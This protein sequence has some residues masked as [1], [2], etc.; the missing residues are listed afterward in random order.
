MLLVHKRSLTPIDP[1]PALKH[2]GANNLDNSAIEGNY[3]LL[4]NVDIVQREGVWH[5]LFEFDSRAT[6]QKGAL[7]QFVGKGQD[8]PDDMNWKTWLGPDVTVITAAVR[9][10]ILRMPADEAHTGAVITDMRQV[11][12]TPPGPSPRDPDDWFQSDT[13]REF[14]IA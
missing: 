12:K 1:W 9:E 6:L 2:G 4:W 7:A 13:P 11:R 14:L 8:Y 3:L 5:Y 10:E